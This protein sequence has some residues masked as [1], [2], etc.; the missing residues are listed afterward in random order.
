M[1]LKVEDFCTRLPRG[2]I[3]GIM[4]F[5][6]PVLRRLANHRIGYFMVRHFTHGGLGRIAVLLARLAHLLEGRNPIDVSIFILRHFFEAFL[7]EARMTDEEA[8]FFLTRCPYGLRTQKDIQLCDAVM[9]LERELVTGIGA[10]LIIE[11]TIPK[12]AHKCR[13]TIRVAP[14]DQPGD[15]LRVVNAHQDRKGT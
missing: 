9:Q 3:A 2:T 6:G 8:V 5:E 10:S 1:M 12:G 13:F 4:A 14:Q 15:R 7:E 11:E